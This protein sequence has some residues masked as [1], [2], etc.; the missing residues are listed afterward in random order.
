MVWADLVE[1]RRLY[2]LG[3]AQGHAEAQFNLGFMHDEGQGGPQDSPEARR[4]Y[5]LAAAQG[6]A[7]AQYN[8]ALMHYQ[9]QGGPQALAEA[10]RLYGLAAAQGDPDCLLYTSPSPRD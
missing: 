8:L 5:G 3:A 2:S 6:N 7:R 1:A 4:L 10:R 9:G